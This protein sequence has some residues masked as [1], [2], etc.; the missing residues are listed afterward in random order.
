MTAA[1]MESS[2]RL[3]PPAAVSTERRREA[4]MMPPMPA[5]ALEIMKTVILM[6]VTLMPARRAASSLPPT[7]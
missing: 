5:R 6:P 1:A 7:A 2:S 3:P 4:R